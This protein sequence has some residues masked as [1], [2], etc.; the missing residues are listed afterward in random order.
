M[1]LF[2]LL[3][4]MIAVFWCA[5]MVLVPVAAAAEA[6]QGT[7]QGNNQM[8]PG[9]GQSMGSEGNTHQQGNGQNPAASGMGDPPGGFG[10]LNTSANRTLHAPGTGTRTAPPD[11][12]GFGN[13]TIK[14][15]P[16]D[17]IADNSTRMDT[18][19]MHRPWSGNQTGEPLP[20]HGNADNST[21]SNQTWHGYGNGN[22]T[23]PAPSGQGNM[24]GQGQQD[25]QSVQ[26]QMN[27][28]NDLIVQLI[29][30]LK[31]HGVS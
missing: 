5:A 3:G 31:D 30:W 7:N 22:L 25:Q 10:N 24:P 11:L 15:V 19:T 28:T 2:R 27:D 9:L 13:M 23:M 4:L 20:P 12:P 26:E 1:K 16:P 18:M 14:P 17:W 21:A 8:Q 29:A 6:G